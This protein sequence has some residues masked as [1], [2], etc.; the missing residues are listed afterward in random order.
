MVWNFHGNDL[1]SGKHRQNIIIL[2]I[3]DHFS[4]KNF[5]SL[6]NNSQITIA[7]MSLYLLKYLPADNSILPIFGGFTI[8]GQGLCESR[9]ATPTQLME[10]VFRQNS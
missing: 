9:A 2:Q 4:A 6:Q 7:R 1:L 10:I 5:V 3:S 8:H